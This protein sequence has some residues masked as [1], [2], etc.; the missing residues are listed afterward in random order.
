MFCVKF[1]PLNTNR[2]TPPEPVSPRTAGIGHAIEDEYA[3]IREN[4]RTPK[5]PIVLAHGLLGFDELHLAGSYL[6]GL[7]YWRGIT[8][9]LRANGIEVITAHVPASGSIEA[10]AAKLSDDIYNK[11]GGKSVNIVAHSMGYGVKP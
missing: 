7:H 11:V 4:Y 9:A 8:E 1:G 6:P 10:R 2:A 5:F 3:A